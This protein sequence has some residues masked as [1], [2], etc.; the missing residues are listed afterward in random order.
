MAKVNM[1]GR[2]ARTARLLLLQ[3]FSLERSERWSKWRRVPQ[4][5]PALTKKSSVFLDDGKTSCDVYNMHEG[6]IPSWTFFFILWLPSTI[7]LV[8]EWDM[9]SLGVRWA[10]V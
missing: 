6:K 2:P 9:L 10:N 4:S 8:P 7:E 5:P 1:D 3:D